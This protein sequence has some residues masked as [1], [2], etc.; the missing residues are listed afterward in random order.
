MSNQ[1][2]REDRIV[3]IATALAVMLGTFVLGVLGMLAVG[4]LTDMSRAFSAAT[5]WVAIAAIG[6]GI[7]YLIRT[8]D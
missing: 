1:R 6:I 2:T 7:G 8:N 5:M 3:T 4:T